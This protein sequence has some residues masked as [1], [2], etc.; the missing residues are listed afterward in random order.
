[1]SSEPT[2]IT[3]PDALRP[4][5]GRFGSGPSKIRRESFDA[6]A[7]VSSTLLGTSHRQAP[8]KNVVH[9]IREGLRTFF[10]LPDG[11]E[12]VLGN[13][14]S[15][16]FW[17]AA[18]FSLIEHRSQ[19]L[20]FGEFSAKFADVA[21]AAPFLEEPEIRKSEPGTR[22]FV[23]TNPDVDVYAYPHN[24]TSTGVMAAVVRPQGADG[25]VCVDATSGAGGLPV[26]ANNYDVYYFA[27]QKCFASE[28]GLWVACMSPAA[29]ERIQ[30]LSASERWIPP[31][32]DLSIAIENSRLNQTYNTP[33][34][35]T[36]ILLAEQTEWLNA[37]G[38]LDWAV[39][40]SAQSSSTLYTWAEQH[41][42]ATPFVSE[43]EDRSL[44]TATIDFD[45]SIDANAVAATLR[46]N[47]IVDTD[48]YRKLGRNQLRIACF[49][50][51]EPDDITKLTAAIDYVIDA[52]AN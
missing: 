11:Y 3:I 15:H 50:A 51:I 41:K 2:A 1:M 34:L 5:D 29:I 42:Y 24:E 14:G 47:G 23:H 9:R 35:A 27:P 30:R 6:L 52:L 40:R 45:E 46:A 37:N 25:L 48:P 12:V 17:D 22:S 31:T 39:A 21:G 32:L 20:V 38:G 13:G 18:A 43:T 10:A 26:D 49:P 16:A 28:G 44:V 4:S 7:A 33:A 19:H 8:V 36:L